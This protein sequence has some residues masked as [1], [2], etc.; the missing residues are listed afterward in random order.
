MAIDNEMVEK[1]AFLAQLKVSDDKLDETRSEFNKILEWV[2]Q[3]NEI[4]TGD[5]E[6]LVSVN[7]QNLVCRE[8]VVNDGHKKDE[9]LAN[10][11]LKEFGYFAVPKV[12]E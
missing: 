6:P 8:D 9:V 12:V 3:L 11:P 1:I 2:E 5:V 7:E 10:A 4:D